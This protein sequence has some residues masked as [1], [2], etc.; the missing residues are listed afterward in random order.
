MEAAQHFAGGLIA[1]LVLTQERISDPAAWRRLLA[2]VYELLRRHSGGD[3]EAAQEL[4]A[5][6]RSDPLT[7]QAWRAAAVASSQR[8]VFR[9]SQ[10]QKYMRPEPDDDLKNIWTLFGERLADLSAKTGQDEAE[11]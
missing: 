6:L 11:R 9:G 3:Q 2:R 8:P 7:S 10:P 5:L 1:G 4:V